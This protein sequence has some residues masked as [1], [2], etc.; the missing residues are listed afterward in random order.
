MIIYENK[1]QSHGRA[2]VVDLKYRIKQMLYPFF[3]AYYKI[4]L[5]IFCPK[6]QKKK[7]KISICAIFRDEACYLREW[8]EFHMI[9]G[10]EH[11]Y[12]Y[13]NFST[14][15]FEEI[16]NPYI[17]K[18]VVTLT[19]WEIPQG[20]MAAYADCVKKYSTETNWIGFIDIDEFV[21][22]NDCDTVS[23]FLETIGNNHPIVIVDWKYFGSS[24]INNRNLNGLV[25]EDFFLGW[26]KYT[27]LGKC[28]YNT[29]YDYAD[30]LKENEFMHVR[31][32]RYK[33]IKLPPVN[34]F[35]KICLF[36]FD[37]VRSLH[38]P[39]QIN[40]YVIKSYHEY[41]VKKSKRGGGVHKLGFHNFEYFYNHDNRSQYP[42]YHIYKYLIKLKEILKNED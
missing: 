15:N 16:L 20:Q 36:G 40:H 4:L 31:W 17:E 1:F 5:K 38:F 30:D 25:T 35:G 11:F 2:V 6:I 13:N 26:E 28:F 34:Q 24:G 18:G 7:Y 8:I 21:V 27:S 12:L 41:V 9:V 39:I 14:D 3:S 37:P 22:P 29:A 23:E 32:G 33:N 42:D 10:V 19:N